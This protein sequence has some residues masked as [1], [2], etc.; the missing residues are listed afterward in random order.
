MRLN[1]EIG[2]GTLFGVEVTIEELLLDGSFVEEILYSNGLKRS[3]CQ[4]DIMKQMCI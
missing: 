2:I 4:V 3:A 1:H